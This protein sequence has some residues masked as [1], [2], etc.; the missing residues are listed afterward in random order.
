MP[1]KDKA[2]DFV[3]A[4]HILEHMSDPG[5]FLKELQRVGKAGY[6]ETPNF[7]YERLHPYAIHCLEVA[8]V[9][10]VLHIHKKNGPVEDAFVSALEFLRGNEKWARLFHQSPDMFHV[11][12]FWSNSIQYQMH[13]PE[14]HSEWIE[15]INE[16]SD[17]GHSKDTY[18]ASGAGWRGAG[19]AALAKFNKWQRKSRLKGLN[20]LDLLACPACHAQLIPGEQVYV[21]ASCDVRYSSSPYPDFTKTCS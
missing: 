4:S 16:N 14:C 11:R 3:V 18:M 1:F 10:G 13:N 2:F 6:I 12:Y 7:I 19:L 9:N 17:H 20:L 5:K 8:D 21:C 15:D